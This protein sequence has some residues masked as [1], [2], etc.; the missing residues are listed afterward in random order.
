M[1]QVNK[2]T[3]FYNSEVYALYLKLS[4]K[5][6]EGVTEISNGINLD[7]THDE[8]LVG[9]EILDASK[10]LDIQTILSYNLELDK[11]ILWKKIA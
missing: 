1:I 9:I 10:K 5:K 2:M 11:N 7:I 8:K 3:I 4:N 6:L